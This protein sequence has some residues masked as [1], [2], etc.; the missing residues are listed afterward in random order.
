[1]GYGKAL[2]GFSFGHKVLLAAFTIVS[3][4]TAGITLIPM[5]D[6]GQASQLIVFLW[7]FIGGAPASMAGGIGL[8][9]LAVMILTLTSNVRGYYEVR[10]LANFAHRNYF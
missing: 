10:V 6:L 5:T 9:T 4:R 3:S 2:S 8:T 1:M 7:M